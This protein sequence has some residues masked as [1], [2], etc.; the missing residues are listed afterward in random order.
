LFL[1]VFLSLFCVCQFFFQFWSNHNSYTRFQRSRIKEKE[2]SESYS[3]VKLKIRRKRDERNILHTLFDRLA[4][5]VSF[6]IFSCVL[7]RA[8]LEA[9]FLYQSFVYCCLNEL[10]SW[11]SQKR[12]SCTC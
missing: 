12:L 3:S 1:V 9:C 6:V 8:L 10:L 2:E 11:W 5:N 7:Y 4:K